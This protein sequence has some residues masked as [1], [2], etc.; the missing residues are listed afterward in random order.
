M[1]IVLHEDKTFEGIDFSE[2]KSSKRE[3][4]DCTF[5]NCHFS[6]GDLGNDDFMDSHLLTVH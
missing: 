4:I 2:K 6:K 3:F 5:I 1:D